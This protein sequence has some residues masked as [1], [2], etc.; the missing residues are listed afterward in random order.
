M[1]LRIINKH[2]FNPLYEKITDS[3]RS[4]QREMRP[5]FPLGGRIDNSAIGSN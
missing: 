5:L 2:S 1:Q 3:I 4:L